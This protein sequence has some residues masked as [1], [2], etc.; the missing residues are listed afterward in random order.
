MGPTPPCVDFAKD[1]PNRNRPI[2][3]RRFSYA[4]RFCDLVR[5][6]VSRNRQL[7]SC[8]RRGGTRVSGDGW[9]EQRAANS[10]K[11]RRRGARNPR[12]HASLA[13]LSVFC[14]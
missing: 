3:A 6:N 12:Q 9:W 2:F 1:V 13:R 11:Q 7:P 10:L 4:H 8:L 5:Q 14:F